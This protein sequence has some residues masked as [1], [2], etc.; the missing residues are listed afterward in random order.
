MRARKTATINIWSAVLAALVGLAAASCGGGGSDESKIEGRFDRW[1]DALWENDYRT[2]YD[3]F[4][5]EYRECTEFD[6]FE[7]DQR[8]RDEARD[9]DPDFDPSKVGTR[10]VEVSVD[11]DEAELRYGVTYD[12]PEGDFL[13]PLGGTSTLDW[14]KV[15]GQW[16]VAAACEDLSSEPDRDPDES[17]VASRMRDRLD[18]IHDTDWEKMYSLLSDRLREGCSES[19][20]VELQEDYSDLPEG[21]DFSKLE[22]EDVVINLSGDSATTTFTWTYD[23]EPESTTTTEYWVKSDG[24]WYDDGAE[25]DADLNACGDEASSRGTAAGETAA[26]TATPRTPT[27]TRTPG[28]SIT[29]SI[30]A[31]DGTATAQANAEKTELAAL[32]ALGYVLINVTDSIVQND[33]PEPYFRIPSTLKAG[34]SQGGEALCTAVARSKYTGAAVYRNQVKLLVV[35]S[36]R[37]EAARPQTVELARCPNGAVG[38]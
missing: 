3:H 21:Y 7:A 11:G 9:T 5:P 27:R 35:F 18:A 8:E 6:D 1:F 32:E 20:F 16:Y 37:D 15:D 30:G 19:D 23:G 4:T 33:G 24:T 34:D 28:A 29:P 31:A 12:G 26:R 13:N 25:E 38:E 17:A 2:V 22:Y 14:V 36:A 10:D